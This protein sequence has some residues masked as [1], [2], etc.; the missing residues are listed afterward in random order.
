MNSR[1]AVIRSLR[2]DWEHMIVN[3]MHNDSVKFF[4]DITRHLE[5]DEEHQNNIL[6]TR[7]LS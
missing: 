1:L 7:E 6:E 5:P 4:G 3:M 2:K